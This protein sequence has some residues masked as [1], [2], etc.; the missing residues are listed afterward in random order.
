MWWIVYSVFI[1]FAA[2][3]LIGFWLGNRAHLDFGGV[4]KGVVLGLIFLVTI[5]YITE[6]Q[7]DLYIWKAYMP[8]KSV[9]D[10]L[11]Q[12]WL[13]NP[14]WR[15]LHTLIISYVFF[16]MAYGIRVFLRGRSANITKAAAKMEA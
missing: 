15:A 7:I 11:G 16:L 13:S 1:S 10:A 4:I 2:P 14:L 6:M 9:S 3:I 12:G 5:F 8:E